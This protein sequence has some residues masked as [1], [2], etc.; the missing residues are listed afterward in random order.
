MAEKGYVRNVFQVTNCKLCCN[1]IKLLCP[2]YYR[3][4]GVGAMKWLRNTEIHD[5][6]LTAFKAHKILQ[7]S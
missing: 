7:K 5:Y 3:K 6:A 1:I 4:F 2:K